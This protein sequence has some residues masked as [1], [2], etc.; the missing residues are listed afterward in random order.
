MHQQSFDFNLPFN[1]GRVEALI[2]HRPLDAE[3]ILLIVHVKTL[4]KMFRAFLPKKMLSEPIERVL[5]RSLFKNWGENFIEWSEEPVPDA[6]A[7]S[8]NG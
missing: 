5:K 8:D 7:S 6:P 3:N 1:M 4:P 2:S